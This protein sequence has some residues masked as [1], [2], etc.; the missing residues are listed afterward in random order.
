MSLFELVQSQRDRIIEVTLGHLQITLAVIAVATLIGVG[1]GMATYQRSRW[2]SAVLGVTGVFLTIPSFAL[3]GIFI[4]IF[5]LGFKPAFV[6]LLMYALLPIVRNTI[7][8]LHSVDPAVVDA[9]RGMGVNRARILLRIELPLAWPVIITGMRVSTMLVV[10]IAAI[11]SFVNGP[12]L[13][14]YIFRGLSTIGGANAFNFVI[15]G[16][17]GVV[18]LGLLLDGAFL[19]LGKFTTPRGIRA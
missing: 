14:F 6:A 15:I 9:A 12:G 3:F 4:P 7:V 17:V 13:G 18:L 16:T 10:G 19:L 11:A 1:L 5:G 8:G 2:A